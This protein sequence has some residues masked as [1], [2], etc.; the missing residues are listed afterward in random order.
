MHLKA[1]LNWLS[2]ICGSQIVKNESQTTRKNEIKY[3]IPSNKKYLFYLDFYELLFHSMNYLGKIREYCS[4]LCN[5]MQRIK[6]SKKD[7]VRIEVK[8]S[9]IVIIKTN[10]CLQTEKK[11]FLYT[12]KKRRDEFLKFYS[13]FLINSKVFDSTESFYSKNPEIK[14]KNIQ[15]NILLGKFYE[16]ID[17][18]MRKMIRNCNLLVYNFFCFGKSA[19]KVKEDMKKIKSL[20]IE[21][22][23]KMK[24][25]KN[26]ISQ[27][28]C[29]MQVEVVSF[30]EK[31]KEMNVL[32]DTRF[33][34][35]FSK[36]LSLKSTNELSFYFFDITQFKF[37]DSIFS[38]YNNLLCKMLLFKNEKITETMTLLEKALKFQEYKILVDEMIFSIS[39]T[40]FQTKTFDLDFENPKFFV[41]LL[42]TLKTFAMILNNSYYEY[43]ISQ[44][45][46]N[47]SSLD[48]KLAHDLELQFKIIYL[49][50]CNYIEIFRV[51]IQY[52]FLEYLNFW[53]KKFYVFV[54][55][56]DFDTLNQHIQDSKLTFDNESECI[57]RS[58]EMV[59]FTYKILLENFESFETNYFSIN[60][61][62]IFDQ[63][64]L[65]L[66]WFYNLRM[67]QVIK[68][69]QNKS[70]VYEQVLS[71]IEIITSKLQKIKTKD[72]KNAKIWNW[73][74]LV[75]A[76]KKNIL[77]KFCNC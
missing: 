16:D 2:L 10:R 42:N 11:I 17:Q 12:L 18:I 32:F 29:N 21:R 61:Y 33:Q 44:I 59:H 57:F 65:I 6:K 27:I 34:Q 48:N 63:E 9:I 15:E 14:D 31:E 41:K 53:L 20:V 37:L 4:Y 38:E 62:I 72:S 60:S 19:F 7:E 23:K 76:S 77:L 71:E 67:I 52:L 13:S 70:F 75:F 55:N 50:T 45:I 54:I 73:L 56:S 51:Y 3:D 24:E 69:R 66:R 64:F 1:F 35:N 36:F 30:F 74:Y 49:E 43:I 5:I 8:K 58:N 68:K 39:K 40:E 28:I 26:S 25:I 46:N 22:N 47:T